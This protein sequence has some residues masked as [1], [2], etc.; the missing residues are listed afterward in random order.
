MSCMK[1]LGVENQSI[2]V[3]L[4]AFETRVSVMAD[5]TLWQVPMMIK[6]ETDS[7]GCVRRKR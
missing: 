5:R 6:A 7:A 4:D 1:Y 2:R 3:S